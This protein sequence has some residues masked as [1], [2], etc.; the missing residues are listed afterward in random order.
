MVN[1]HKRQMNKEWKRR[2]RRPIIAGI[3]AGMLMVH[4]V[5]VCCHRRHMLKHRMYPSVTGIRINESLYLN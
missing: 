4:G 1:I 2:A 3:T 5:I